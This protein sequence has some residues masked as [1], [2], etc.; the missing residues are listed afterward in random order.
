MAGSRP[1]TE[2]QQGGGTN[3]EG[4]AL[5]VSA[6]GGSTDLAAVGEARITGYNQ[7]EGLTTVHVSAVA[8]T[9]YRF[10]GWQVD[11]ET[12]STLLSADISYSD[13]EGKILVA[14]FAPI[15]NNT[16]NSQTD[17]GYIDDFV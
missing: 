4:V 3:I 10:V 17:N 2:L 9:G 6:S 12:I 15:D 16:Q 1:Q 14:V 5:Q 8:S 13:V 7:T 11:G